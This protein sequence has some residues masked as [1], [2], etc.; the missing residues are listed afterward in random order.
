[1]PAT[2]DVA[3]QTQSYNVKRQT[4]LLPGLEILPSTGNIHSNQYQ[5][6]KI[7][8]PHGQTLADM[9]Q[10]TAILEKKVTGPIVMTT[11]NYGLINYD[12]EKVTFSQYLNIQEIRNNLSSSPY[13]LKTTKPGQ[14]FFYNLDFFGDL[15]KVEENDVVEFDVVYNSRSGI[16]VAK[17]VQLIN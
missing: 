7:V 1:M 15:R 5:T 6:D 11:E 12:I 16:F 8:A 2:H 3:T 4:S 13:N 10:N 14:I 17:N 9:H